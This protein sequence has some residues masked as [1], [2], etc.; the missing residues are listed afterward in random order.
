MKSLKTILL[1][2][3]SIGVI[4]L[5]FFRQPSS[6]LQTIKKETS[7]SIEVPTAVAQEKKTPAVADTEINTP[8]QQSKLPILVIGTLVHS[9]PNQSLTALYN[10]KNKQSDIYVNRS[11]F[12]EGIQISKIERG[13][14]YFQNLKTLRIE[15]LKLNEND[16]DPYRKEIQASGDVR[17]TTKNSFSVK[18]KN[19]DKYLNDLSKTLL[20]A[21][22]VP[23]K[24]SLGEIDGFQFVDLLP[25]G[26]FS[27]LGFQKGDTIKTV[28]G[29]TVDSLQKGIETY[30]SLKESKGF[31]IQID[32]DGKSETFEYQIP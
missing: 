19:L 7:S 30:N 6:S 10:K 5:L 21:S 20:T 9:D 25:M 13:I 12:T 14:V 32:R 17:Q 28:N 2:T 31:K 16:L 22:V 29:E 23:H 8:P 26:I 15:F 11:F 3:I 1:I 18:R 27:Q 4:F 24:N